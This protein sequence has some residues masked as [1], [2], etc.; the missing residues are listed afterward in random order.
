MLGEQPPLRRLL[1][2]GVHGLPC[3]IAQDDDPPRGE[4]TGPDDGRGDL[5]AVQRAGVGRAA[6][7]GQVARDGAAKTAAFDSRGRPVRPP[8]TGQG[9]EQVAV[10]PTGRVALTTEGTLVDVSTGRRRKGVKGIEGEDILRTGAFS[11]DGRYLAAADYRGRV[12]LWDAHTWRRTAVLRQVGS[13]A[14]GTA[15]AFSADG[16]LLAAGTPDG[17]VEVWE[18]AS[19]AL[20]P[21]TLPV[22]DGPVLALGFTPGGDEIHAATPHL[23]DRSG[24]LTPSRAAATVCARAGGGPTS[25]EWHRYLPSVPYR[26]PCGDA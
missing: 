8:A 11:R 10:D 1:R 13:T 5:G 17:S 7:Q 9:S 24:P 25:T 26:T 18:T 21:A 3:R 15:L 19:P 6:V 2:C 4:D 16:A 12:T 23:P 22:G 14:D 20:P